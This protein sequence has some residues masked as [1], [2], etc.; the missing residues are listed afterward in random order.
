MI[1]EHG[2]FSLKFSYTYGIM[3]KHFLEECIMDNDQRRQGKPLPLIV[4]TM[5]GRNL[6]ATYIDFRLH[7]GTEGFRS[8]HPLSR[9]AEKCLKDFPY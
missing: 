2:I 1:C 7:A 9:S 4:N 8:P 3:N 6:Q 5:P